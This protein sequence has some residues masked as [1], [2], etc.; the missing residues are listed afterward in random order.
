M[1]VG[2]RLVAVIIVLLVAAIMV[3]AL[4]SNWAQGS[5]GIL[6]G[7]LNWVKSLFGG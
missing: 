4:M 1:E 7:F 3:I 6:E 5:G 2:L